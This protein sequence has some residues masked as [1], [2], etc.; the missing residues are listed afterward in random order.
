MSYQTSNIIYTLGIE[1]CYNKSVYLIPTTPLFKLPIN[2]R[3]FRPQSIILGDR[4]KDS[5]SHSDVAQSESSRRA[6]S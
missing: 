1:I 5:E 3:K 2:S 6:L 4:T